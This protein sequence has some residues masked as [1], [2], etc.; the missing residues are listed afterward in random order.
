VGRRKEEQKQVAL[1]SSLGFG[2]IE[3]IDADATRKMVNS[4]RYL[5]AVWEPRLLLMDPARLAREEK[6]HAI[7]LGAYIYENSPVLAVAK[8]RGAGGYR[9]LTPHGFG[10]RGQ[11][12]VC[13]QRLLAPV[14]RACPAADARLYLHDRHS[15][16]DRRAARPDRLGRAAGTG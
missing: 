10:D 1:M 11:T 16:A 14:R 12:G 8:I 6:R 7:T 15:A 9:L 13:H 5:G 2:G 4:G 3:W